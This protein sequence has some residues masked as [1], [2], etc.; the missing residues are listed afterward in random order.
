MKKFYIIILITILGITFNSCKKYKISTG[1]YNFVFE[2]V[3]GDA[4]G[5]PISLSFEIIESTREYVIIES[6]YRDT[7]YK[8]GT[9]ISGTLTRHGTIAG[10]GLG[11]FY[12][13]FDIIG[14]Y[15]KKNGVYSI[16]GSF[17]SKVIIPNPDEETMD[18]IDT[19]G[20][21]ELIPNF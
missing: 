1:E 4:H 17:E 13:S 7:L 6:S 3:N 19:S 12:D 14:V 21:F 5:T 9:E 18:T 16:S 15:E 10:A 2:G 11:I 8:N 20:V